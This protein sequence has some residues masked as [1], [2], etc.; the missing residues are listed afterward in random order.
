MFNRSLLS[1][2]QTST[3]KSKTQNV[4]YF[5]QIATNLALYVRN[6]IANHSADHRTTYVLFSPNISESIQRFV[7]I[8]VNMLT[9]R[10]HLNMKYVF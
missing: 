5:L 10:R 9:I 6:A 4:K 1:R 2:Y 8:S 7:R 3:N